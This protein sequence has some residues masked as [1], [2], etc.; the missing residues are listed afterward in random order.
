[1]REVITQLAADAEALQA[2]R[3]WGAAGLAWSRVAVAAE[4]AEKAMKKAAKATETKI[5]RSP[6]ATHLNDFCRRVSEHLSA[7]EEGA[8]SNLKGKISYMGN[9]LVRCPAKLL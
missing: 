6:P 9:V 2:Q 1:M 8:F 3:A 7:G 5:N 4:K